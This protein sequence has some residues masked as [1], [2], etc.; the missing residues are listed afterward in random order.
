MS[1]RVFSPLPKIESTPRE[2]YLEQ[3]LWVSYNVEQTAPVCHL[4]LARAPH[5]D[6][7]SDVK[8]IQKFNHGREDT[9]LGA[10]PRIL[11]G[12][13]GLDN[14]VQKNLEGVCKVN[15]VLVVRRKRDCLLY[16]ASCQVKAQYVM[17]KQV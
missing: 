2:T 1:A 8:V 11:A 13:F 10:R 17:Q 16:L 9:V 4:C 5:D 15:E 14:G 12:R 3:R 7:K 6:V